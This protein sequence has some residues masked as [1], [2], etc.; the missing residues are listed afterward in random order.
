MC[1]HTYCR[2]L[3]LL[4][5]SFSVH[6]CPSYQRPSLMIITG[7]T[8]IPWRTAAATDQHDHWLT[9][10]RANYSISSISIPFSCPFS[11]TATVRN[12]CPPNHIVLTVNSVYTVSFIQP[13]SLHFCPPPFYGCTNLL[14]TAKHESTFFSLLLSFLSSFQVI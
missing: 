4:H 5:S 11:S 1:T 10:Q 14:I 7:Q 3:L 8:V 6:L 12:Q 2:K 9:P 13:S